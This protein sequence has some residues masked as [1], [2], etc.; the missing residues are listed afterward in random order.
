MNFIVASTFRQSLSKLTTEEQRI[1]KQSVF[2]F[3]V[4]PK[5]PSFQFHR[6]EKGKDKDFWTARVNDDIRMVIHH[7]RNDMVF[8]YVDHHD[9]AYAWAQ[10]RRLEIHPQTGAAQLVEILERQEHVVR[11]VHKDVVEE[12]A[13]LGKYEASYLLALGVPAE[14]VDA[15]RVAGETALLEL[16]AH[17]PQEAAERLLDLAAGRPVPTPKAAPVGASPFAH[18]DAQRGFRV[19]DSVAELRQALETPWEQWIVYLHPIQRAVATREFKGAAR[20]S[21][22]AG[23][24][25]TVVAIHRAVHLAKINPKARVLLTSYSRTLAARLGQQT[26]MLIGL[27]PKV[28]SRIETSNVHKLARDVWIAKTGKKRVRAIDSAQLHELIDRVASMAKGDAF[29]TAFLRAEWDAVVDPLGIESWEVYKKTSRAGRA[30]P[31][32]AKQRQTIWRIFEAVQVA[33]RDQGLVTWNQLCHEAATFLDQA[34]ANHRF[35]HVV[36]DECQDFGPAELRFVRALVKPSPNDLFFCG[37]IGQ[38]IYKGKFSWSSQGIDVRGRTTRLTVNYRT[39]EQIRRFADAFMPAEIIDSDGGDEKRDAVSLL[40]GPIPQ[41]DAFASPGKEVAAIAGWIKS[42]IAEGFKPRDI[43]IFARTDALLRDRAARALS[44]AGVAAHPLDD[45]EPP[46]SQA[47][48]TG[49][50]H[51]AKGLEF[52]AVAVIGCDVGVLP[53]KAAMKDLVDDADRDAFVEQERQLLYVACTRAR[54]RLLIT[55]AGEPCVFLADAP[56]SATPKAIPKPKKVASN[57][58]S[59]F[60]GYELLNRL[61]AGGM[62]E[63]FKARDPATKEVVF[64]KRVLTSSRDAEALARETDIYGRLQYI[65]CDHLVKVRDFV[66]EGDYAALVTELADG[67]DLAKYVSRRGDGGLP[68]AEA[69]PVALD[70]ALG[71]Q[72][73]HELNIVHRDLKPANVLLAGNKW[74]LADFGI[75]KDHERARPGKTFLGAG[76]HGYGAPEQFEGVMAAPSAD[77]YSFGKMATFLLTGDTV[78]ADVPSKYRE[79]RKLI[80]SCVDPDPESRPAIKAVV[81]LLK[82]TID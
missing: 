51:R 65:D 24:G 57:Q 47:A 16:C 3:E 7:Q 54:E 1:V 45:D 81:D 12:P 20:V 29:S 2:D 38:R 4:N 44:Q 79:W 67:G 74:K 13:V 46:S 55:S 39:T 41:I 77:V 53:L 76:T 31:L 28:R 60:A 18:P 69:A 34:G 59:L 11:R 80:K 5:Q 6:L 21:G 26:D 72:A 73:L 40:S 58:A 70:I 50:M 36:V 30:T 23:T 35:E 22:S 82:K 56:G 64:L 8:C 27:E 10:K 25:K 61:D 19:M 9:A 33:M 68:A 37:D 78:I 17:L 66:R 63:V 62:A 14:W 15:A 32:G 71:I 52:K 75:A 43:A 48:A 42:L 49:T